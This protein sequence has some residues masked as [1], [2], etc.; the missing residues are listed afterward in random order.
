MAEVFSFRFD[1]FLRICEALLGNTAVGGGA[2]D[3]GR[4]VMRPSEAVP[5]GR[6]MF[7][8]VFRSLPLKIDQNIGVF[9]QM[10]RGGDC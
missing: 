3:T 7:T 9:R 6:G 5:A 4:R 1:R 2:G 10:L 8:D